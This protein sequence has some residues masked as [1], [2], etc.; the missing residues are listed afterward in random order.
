MRQVL[1]RV[2]ASLSVVLGAVTL[3]FLILNWLPGDPATLIAGSEANEEM[4]GRVRAQLGLGRP[5]AEQY[6]EY[7]AGLL[8]GDLGTS[9]VTREPV[10]ERILSQFPATLSL[11]LSAT[12]LAVLVGVGLGVLS[13]R[14]HGRWLDQVIQ[15]AALTLVSVPVFWLGILSILV[16]SV[17]LRWLPV[18]D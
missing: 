1:A 10:L 6:W 9:Y 18:L 15:S 4:I 16:F 7:L 13:A 3:L 14:H 2:V 5:I 11:A 12:G 8:R 17:W